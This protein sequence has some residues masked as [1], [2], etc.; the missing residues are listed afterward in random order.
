[1]PNPLLRVKYNSAKPHTR[2][3]SLRKAHAQTPKRECRQVRKN[4]VHLSFPLC[5]V[6]TRQLQPFSKQ[7]SRRASN[8]SSEPNQSSFTSFTEL[9]R[10]SPQ[11]ATVLRWKTVESDCSHVALPLRIRFAVFFLSF[12][13]FNF[14]LS[15]IVSNYGQRGPSSFGGR[16]ARIAS[17]KNIRTGTARVPVFFQHSKQGRG[18]DPS[19]LWLCLD[20]GSF[21]DLASSGSSWALARLS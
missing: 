19:W 1:M 3:T 8:H 11:D 10:A 5:G 7:Y 16:E 20:S 9:L 21:L 17:V 13:S 2:S 4:R 12:L 18:T 14:S 6:A 15:S